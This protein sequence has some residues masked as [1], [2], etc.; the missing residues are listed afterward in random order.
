[1]TRSLYIDYIKALGIVLVILYHCQYVPLGSLLIQGVYAICVSL[2]FMVNGY[3]MLRK[4]RSISDL[5]KKNGKFLIVLFAW[6]LFSTSVSMMCWGDWPANGALGGGKML[7]L[8]SLFIAKPYCN[9]LWF[10]KEIFVLNLLNPIIYAFVHGNDKRLKYLLVI[11]GVCTIKFLDIV[12]CRFTNPLLN[13]QTSFS[14]F[15]YVLGYAIL[16]EGDKVMEAKVETAKGNRWLIVGIVGLV[17]LQWGY[18]WLLLRGP[19]ADLNRAKYW[20]SDIVWDGYNAPFIVGLTAMVVL[21]F[22]RI[23]WRT[24]RWVQF[25][26]QYSLAIYVMQTP[27]Q[28]VWEWILPLSDWTKLCHELRIILPVLTL[29]TCMILTKLL[30]TNKYTRYWIE[31]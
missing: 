4:E 11:L 16:K 12:V 17:L 23:E 22:Q 8:K 10:L 14:V 29:G 6:A 15:Y 13:W 2:F 19:L 24:C 26:G 5:L 27:V 21:L 30:L 3:L 7:V 18:N 31:I 20:V 1:M 28:R 25:I 9:H